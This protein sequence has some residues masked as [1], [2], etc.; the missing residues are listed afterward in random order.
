MSLFEK[1]TFRNRIVVDYTKAQSSRIFNGVLHGG[2][3]WSFLMHNF[4]VTARHA[5][6][7]SAFRP[8][9]ADDTKPEATEALT[10]GILNCSLGSMVVSQKLNLLAK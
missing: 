4:G 6:L 5:H 1:E 9:F 3:I 7:Q 10:C 8:K 2:Y